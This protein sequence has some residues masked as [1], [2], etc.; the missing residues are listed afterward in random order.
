MPTSTTNLSLY[1]YDTTTDGDLTFNFKDSL[2]DNWDKIDAYCK[3]LS[4]DKAN[5]S[6]VNSALALKADTSAVNSALALKADTSLSNLSAAGLDK[7]HALKAYSDN[8]ELLTDAEGLADVKKYAHSTFDL[9]KFIQQGTPTVSNDGILTNITNTNHIR[10]ANSYLDFTAPN[11]SISQGFTFVEGTTARGLF[12]WADS[13]K[14]LMVSFTTDNKA[15]ARISSDGSNW[16]GSVNSN[17]LTNGHFYVVT[18]NR[19]NGTAY[20]LIVKDLTAGTSTSYEVA[21]STAD[22]HN[23]NTNLKIGYLVGVNAYYGAIDLKYTQ[24]TVN[25][26]EVFSGNKT[27]IDTIKP[28]D[29]TVVGTPTISAD[30]VASGFSDSNYIQCST[31]LSNV[32]KLNIKGRATYGLNDVFVGSGSNKS[33][34]LII[35]DTGIS[36]YT[37]DGTNTGTAK[38]LTANIPVSSGEYFYF[39]CEI[40]NS[41]RIL[42]ISADGVTWV[43][44][45]NTTALSLNLVNMIQTLTLGRYDSSSYFAGS[46]DLNAF[47]IYVDGNLVYQPCLKIPY[48]KGSEQYGGKYVNAQ[49]L[50][51]VKDAYEQGLANDYFTLDEVN[52]TYTL[53]MGNLYGMIEKLNQLAKDEIGLPKA[54]LSNTLNDNEIWLEGAEVSKVTYAKLYA[55]YGDDYGTPTDSANFVLPDF[56]DRV[57][58]GIGSGET[59]GYISAGLP[60]ITGSAD[61]YT[62]N[63]NASIGIRN[64]SGA[65]YS[66]NTGSVISRAETNSGQP[67]ILNIDA[68]RSSSIYGN[69]T[70]VQPPAIKVRFK[71]RFQ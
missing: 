21:S 25:G 59:F 9:S 62:T 36:L 49:Y 31:S 17:T 57:M 38:I 45:T 71:T 23:D 28:D 20:N 46:I 66:S 68:S 60:N 53:P 64:T 13:A 8:G 43:S 11:W 39:D 56:R 7:L 69:S 14:V 41:E 26:V 10:V 34:R 51:R 6:A 70:T 48:T 61:P 30:G 19:V 67:I 32:S 15:F 4:D 12:G 3:G 58:Q 2:N 22:V 1:K 54:T 65:L 29:Y 18:L 35:R 33:P 27:G 44:E 47:K 5:T 16:L 63:S 37:Y 42:K 55:I 40:S 52:G 24:I 50:P